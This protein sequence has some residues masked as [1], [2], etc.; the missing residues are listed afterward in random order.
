MRRLEARTHR[1][2]PTDLAGCRDTR[3]VARAL[4][5]GGQ[6][7]RHCHHLAAHLTL[8]GMLL[9]IVGRSLP[10]PAQDGCHD[11]VFVSAVVSHGVLLTD[12]DHPAQSPDAAGRETATPSSC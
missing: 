11:I 10:S 8:G 7:S 9:Q 4:L 6:H 5:I 12:N 3:L 1:G 2:P